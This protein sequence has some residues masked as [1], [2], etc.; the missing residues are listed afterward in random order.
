[1]ATFESPALSDDGWG[2]H[3]QHYESVLD[4]HVVSGTVV[5]AEGWSAT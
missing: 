4:E 2:G 1:M 3:R 5:L